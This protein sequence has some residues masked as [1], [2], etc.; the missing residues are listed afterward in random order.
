MYFVL[1]CDLLD[2]LA[3]S[4]HL[5]L[6]GCISYQLVRFCDHCLSML[7]LQEG[8]IIVQLARLIVDLRP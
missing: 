5:R 3:K 8:D 4:D 2:K 7:V 1:T 6:F